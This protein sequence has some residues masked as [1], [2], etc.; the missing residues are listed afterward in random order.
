MSNI[1]VLHA[2]EWSLTPSGSH[3]V[4]QDRVVRKPGARLDVELAVQPSLRVLAHSDATECWIGPLATIELGDL[5]PR[6]S[7][8]VDLAVEVSAALSLVQAPVAGSP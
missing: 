3:V 2:M 4:P 7:L 5:L 8:G 1:F 6:P